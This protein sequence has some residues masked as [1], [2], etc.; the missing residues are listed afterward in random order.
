M[1]LCA[2]QQFLNCHGSHFFP[3]QPILGTVRR[4]SKKS[5]VRWNFFFVSFYL[6]VLEVRFKSDLNRL[7]VISLAHWAAWFYHRLSKRQDMAASSS[8]G[9]EVINVGIRSIHVKTTTLEVPQ[10]WSVGQLKT[11]VRTQS[12]IEAFKQANGISFTKSP[13]LSHRAQI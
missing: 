9:S 2:T 10:K 7:L 8:D 6:T 11:K 12:I 13:F 1:L 4:T 3:D 5:I